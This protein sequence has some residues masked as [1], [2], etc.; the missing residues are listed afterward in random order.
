M[1]DYSRWR[2]LF[3]YFTQN[4]LCLSC[5]LSD[6]GVSSY[7]LYTGPIGVLGRVRNTLWFV[8][9]ANTPNTRAASE[10]PPSDEVKVNPKLH[11]ALQHGAMIHLEPKESETTNVQ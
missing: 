5:V 6:D 7:I 1:G 11:G 3:I 4:D 10:M 2:D 9:P 8:N